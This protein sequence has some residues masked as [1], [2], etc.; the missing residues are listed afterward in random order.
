M[1]A[2]PFTKHTGS[3]LSG[4][5]KTGDI[6]SVEPANLNGFNFAATGLKWYNGPEETG[7][8][9]SFEGASRITPDGTYSTLNFVRSA[10]LTDQSFIDLVASLAG[11]SFVNTTNAAAWLS[12]NGYHTT[13][14]GAPSKFGYTYISGASF[15]I[16]SPGTAVIRIDNPTSEVKYI[17]LRGSSPYQ[18]S[19]SNIGS[20]ASTG[21]TGSPISMTNTKTSP[22]QTFNGTS[23]ITVPANTSNLQ[24]SVTL[25]GNGSMQLV[26]TDANTPT[27][28]NI[29]ML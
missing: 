9:I 26:Y 27:K 20:A 18:S 7:H 25:G 6:S 8:I 16:S 14:E 11:Q 22:G 15:P 23:S 29:P 13:F 28:T 4:T 24:F 1:A 2:R 21:L 10:N 5:K 3:Q 17:W 19:G 12:S